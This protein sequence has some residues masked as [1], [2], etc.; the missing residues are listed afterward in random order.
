M[1]KDFTPESELLFVALGGSGEIGMNVNLYGCEGK[2]L[3]VDLGMTFASTWFSP[4][5]TSSNSGSTIL[6]ASC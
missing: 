5:S 4:I 3:M 1:K 2:W 6:S